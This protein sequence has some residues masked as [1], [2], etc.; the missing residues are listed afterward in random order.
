MRRLIAAAAATLTLLCTG[1]A[2]VVAGPA[3]PAAAVENGLARTPPM[4]FN[5]WNA[6]GCDVTEQLIKDVADLFVSSGLQAVGYEY[7]NIDDCWALKERDPETGRLVPDPVKFPSGIAGVAGYVHAKGLKLGL[8]ADAGTR[9][10][11]GYPGSLG[12]EDL[13]ARTF[14]EWQIDYLKYDNCYNESDG[15]QADYLRRYTA[16]GQALT[17][18]GRPIVYSICE[19]GTSQPWTWAADVGNL[20]RTTGDISDN[21]SSVRSII[22]TNAPLYPYAGPGH[23]NDPDMLEVGNG[24]MTATEYRTHMS[25]WAMMAAPLI[26]GTDLRGASAETMDILTNSEIIAVDQDPLGVQATVVSDSGGLMVLD[27]PLADGQRAIALYNSTDT[28]ATVSVPATE[29]GLRRAPAYRLQDLWTGAVTQA[30]TTIE[31]AVP[32]H[33]TV[34][35]KV[36]PSTPH[37]RT[38]PAVTVG[39][40]ASTLIPAPAG[41]GTLATVATHRGP[42]TLRDVR[43]DIAAPPGW[44]VTATSPAR[45]RSLVTDASLATAW[46]IGVPEGATAGRY[47]F[48]VTATYRWGDGRVSATSTELAATLVTAPVDGRRHLSTI[49]PFGSVNGQGPVENDRSNGGP[50]AE[51]GNLITIGDAVYTRGLGVSAPSEIRY[52]LGGRCTRLTA[53]VGIDVEDGTGA[54]ARFVVYADDTAVATV[55]AAPGAPVALDADV[56]GAAWLRLVMTGEPGGEA[57]HGDW[58]VPVLTC[59]E[60]GPADPVQPVERVL[61]SFEDGTD[62]W[63]IA[64]ADGGGSVAS[65]SLFHTDGGQALL[66]RAPVNGNWFGR[67]LSEPLDLG[68]GQVLKVDLR[69]TGAGSSGEIAVQVGD[70]L[71]W[72]QGGQWTWTGAGGSRTITRALDEISC[73]AGVTLDRDRVRGVWV[74]LN[75]GGD[76]YLDALR[77]G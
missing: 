37:A 36:R 60:A 63:T 23:W 69:T 77:V 40:T 11:A 26:I 29:T 46:D 12:H 18:T 35:F 65:T 32:A 5:N 66:A 44:T 28:V 71:S 48:T 47:P 68:D 53:D 38:A 8:Y 50:A 21:W 30:R 52:Y 61:F 58:A 9:T 3:A 1:A 31:A 7:V 16:M 74:F 27:K 67:T 43:V 20:W 64:N 56:T 19:W 62:E 57:V 13:D 10:C 4:G 34:V 49:T 76:V 51:D 73:P 75:G 24:G 14:A 59:G 42:G 15:S 2:A 70:D 22:A 33:G 41:A 72:C 54:S 6:F 17:R 55:T 45:T 25:M 39:G